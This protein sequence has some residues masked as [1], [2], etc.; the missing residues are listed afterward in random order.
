MS[1]I[2]TDRSFRV[3]NTFFNFCSFFFLDAGTF[4]L[5]NPLFLYDCRLSFLATAVPILIK[6]KSTS[7][8]IWSTFSKASGR[9]SFIGLFYKI[10]VNAINDLF[11]KSFCK[12]RL[13]GVG[14]RV[15]LVNNLLF[16]DLGYSHRLSV[17]IPGSISVFSTSKSKYQIF[18]LFGLN[19]TTVKSFY[20]LL[21]SFKKIDAYKGKGLQFF[22]TVLQ[23]KK[24]KKK[25]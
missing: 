20:S 8:C 12:I 13:S 18:Y 7:V 1:S 17:I 10:L 5:S 19:I 23:L 6:H 15:T 3:S 16:L 11:H 14:Y 4:Q 2:S 9:Q 21:Q 25:K 24:G 22:N